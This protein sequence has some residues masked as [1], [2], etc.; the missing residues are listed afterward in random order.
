MKRAVTFMAIITVIFWASLA[1]PTGYRAIKRVR[2]PADVEVTSLTISPDGSKLAYSAKSGKK[3]SIYI[4]DRRISPE[5][6]SVWGSV[7]SPDGSKVAY[8]AKSGEKCSLWINEKKV[9]PE[10][11]YTTFPLFS[12]DGFKVAYSV[13]KGGTIKYDYPRGGRWFVMVN[14][15]KVSP[16]FDQVAFAEEHFKKTGE[17]IFAGYDKK[18]H[19]ILLAVNPVGGK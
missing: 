14:D 12:P 6:D 10:F 5:F 7:F 18:R 9:S 11:E 1:T 16:E 15:K 2:I 13:N 4:D 8:M 19:E 3:W 17:L